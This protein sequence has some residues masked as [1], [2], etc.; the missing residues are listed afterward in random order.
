VVVRIRLDRERVGIHDQRRAVTSSGEGNYANDY[1][2]HRRQQ[3]NDELD[4]IHAEYYRRRGGVVTVTTAAATCRACILS[5]ME[6][7]E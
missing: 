1:H 3:R 7:L 2:E 4:S 5:I 6:N